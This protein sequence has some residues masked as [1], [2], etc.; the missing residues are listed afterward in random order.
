M[1]LK[2]PSG[3]GYLDPYNKS[4]LESIFELI[5]GKFELR[6]NFS[7]LT[8][9][10]VT[11]LQL[12]LYRLIQSIRKC[13]GSRA[14]KK[15][16]EKFT[17]DD[18]N[19]ELKYTSRKRKIEEE[20]E[21]AKA[22]QIKTEN[23]LEK[24]KNEANNKIATMDKRMQIMSRKLITRSRTSI[25]GSKSTKNYSKSH[26]R[27]LKKQREDNCKDAVA[28]LKTQEYT[29]IKL[30]VKNKNGEFEDISLIEPEAESK[31]ISRKK[32][33]NEA[34]INKYLY[35]KDKFNVSNEAY[36]EI[37][38]L[39]QDLPRSHVIKSKA[40]EL[41]SLFD[42]K[43]IER[44]VE[45]YQQSIRGV[46]TL[47]L[48]HYL[49]LMTNESFPTT[50]RV[51]L[52]GDG[53]WIGSK[54]HVINFT[55]TL[56]D[57]P[58]AKSADGNVLLAIFKGSENY[59]YLQNALKDIINETIEFTS[60]SLQGK[61]YQI[62]Y[63]IGGDLKF[64]NVVCGID[65]CASKYS[66]IW[67]KCPADQRYDTT[68]TWSMVDIKKGGARTV[69]E[70]EE[71]SKKRSKSEKYNCSN[72]PL[73]PSIPLTRVVPDTLH[74]FL[75]IC[76]QLINQLIKDLMHEDNVTN[77]TRYTT[78]DNIKH[79]H[80][81][82]FE[83]F[84]K[85]KGISW[86]FYVDKNTK[87]IKHRDFTGPEKY[88]ILSTINLSTL[89]PNYSKTK[90]DKMEVIWDG[91]RQLICKLDNLQGDDNQ[92]LLDFSSS[93]KTWL[94]NYVSVYPTKDAT[95]YM[96]ILAN[97]A[98][99]AIEINGKLSQFTQQGLEK[100]NDHVTKWYYRST[101]LSHD[102]AMK[103]IIE[104]QSRLRQLHFSGASRCPKFQWTCKKCDK[105]GHSSKT[106]VAV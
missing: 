102:A 65:S 30:I 62:D 3:K 10:T 19:L 56:P 74:L 85:E 39:N 83:Q 81:A 14:I 28:F 103:Q 79:K 44:G 93:A 1:L 105:K 99:E 12:K 59:I 101:S 6:A 75:R 70:I 46:L 31:S 47:I 51:K 97:H 95:P 26:I 63:Y 15:Q 61:I 49:K 21:L 48:E 33:I 64:L 36:H 68:K 66:C 4:H 69:K 9:T 96:H 86:S 92:K 17:K 27:R 89:L 23:E 16:I 38:M 98:P 90:L 11:R 7:D 58:C 35:A 94:K 5:K 42:I 87:L 55:F 20:L 77:M 57:F 25:P 2:S 88:K 60:V 8:D 34:I 54:L 24:V 84:I 18:Y 73:F 29:P 72:P 52:S 50:I 71:C 37:A 32:T 13:S 80:I 82:G 106:C 40:K 45:G 22:K 76:D 104:K 91:F 100:L 67:C 41:N 43:A 53:T 78:T